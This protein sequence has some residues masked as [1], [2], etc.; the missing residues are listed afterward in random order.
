[1]RSATPS[2]PGLKREASEALSL[3]SIPMADSQSLSVN[4]GGV[5][6]SKKFSSREVDLSAMAVDTK[7]KKASIEAELKDAISDSL[8]W[9]QQKRGQHLR[10]IHEVSNV[11]MK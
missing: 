3:N 11:M 9:I 10:Y 6:K 1:M 2:I 4:R 7:S 8:L 5:L